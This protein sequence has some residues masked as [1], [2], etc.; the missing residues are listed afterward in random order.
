MEVEQQHKTSPDLLPAKNSTTK[1]IRLAGITL[2]ATYA[3]ILVGSSVRASGAGMGCPDWPTCFGMLIPPISV[4]QLPPDYQQI[5]A[6]RGYADTAFNPAKTWIEFGNRMTSLIV[7]LLMLACLIYALISQRHNRP[8][9]LLLV[10]MLGITALQSWIGSVVVASNLHPLIISTHMVLALAII[11]FLHSILQ[12]ARPAARLPAQRHEL[13]LFA[14]GMLLVIQTGLGLQVRE[15]VDLLG[16]TMPYIRD[17][18]IAEL[19]TPFTL[20]ML[21]GLIVLNLFAHTQLRLWRDE[22]LR[23][24]LGNW[25]IVWCAALVANMLVGLALWLLDLPAVLQPLHLLCA[26][27]QFGVIWHL[28]LYLLRAKAP[29][30]YGNR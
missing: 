30:A 8:L 23:Q 4:T 21:C 28:L 26:S 1:F 27:I 17:S 7:G 29:A 16:R 5:Y 10:A 3:L 18:W 25:I 19:G 15:T 6:N 11:A 9:L 2:I 20:H 24:Q 14:C 22:K 13:W 12:L